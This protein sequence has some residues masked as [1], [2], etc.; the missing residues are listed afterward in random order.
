MILINP[1]LFQPRLS[2]DTL[3]TALVYFMCDCDLSALMFEKKSFVDLLELCNPQTKGLLVKRSTL[4]KHL[5]TVYRFHQKH[6]YDKYLSKA[7][8]ISYTP[9][10]WTSPNNTA[11]MAITA[12]L[13]TDKFEKL[14][15]LLAIP[16]I[17]G[18]KIIH[19][20]LCFMFE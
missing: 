11:F 9:D 7:Q 17:E 2:V 20:F 1:H 10:G 5:D 4:S 14:D 3:K 16:H 19:Y 12:H 8:S 13:I 15:V 6:L 18:M